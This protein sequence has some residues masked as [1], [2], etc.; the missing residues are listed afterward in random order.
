MNRDNKLCIIPC[1]SAK[2]WDKEPARGAT[3]AQFV[4]TGVFAAT[5]QRYA[6]A[7]YGNWMILS[8]KHGF[9]MP[10]DHVQ[11]PYDV[12][13]IK[14][15]D[16]QITI[17]ALREQAVDKRFYEYDEIIVLGG[18][19]Y[20]K[21][22]QA[23]L[24]ENQNLILP[25][26]DCKGIGYMLQRL[27]Q[28]LESKEEAKAEQ[29]VVRQSISSIS[30]KIS[31]TTTKIGKYAPLHSWLITLEVTRIVLTIEE[32]ENI[33]GFKL[34]ASAHQHRAWWSNDFSHSQAKSW[35]FA[36]WVVDKVNLPSI[37]FIRNE[38]V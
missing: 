11:E 3:E 15:S 37:K 17:D 29:V 28:S 7:F 21:R 35:L 33:L 16:E 24:Q 8:A 4:Y 34:P 38:E 14:A 9:L 18:K 27:T 2:I 5:C 6:K 1:G 31:T 26:S 12:S 22:V 19:H 13:F 36:G 23:L 20:I 25:L 10:D 30:K 32:L